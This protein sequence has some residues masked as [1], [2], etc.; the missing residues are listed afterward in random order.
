MPEGGKFSAER[1]HSKKRDM[2][3]RAMTKT[4]AVLILGKLI[5]LQEAIEGKKTLERFEP[6]S[7]EE[8]PNRSGK[9]KRAGDIK[10]NCQ[11]REG[12]VKT[13]GR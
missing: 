1:A 10:V 3:K 6:I 9:E 7:E 12:G 13:D 8:K 4:E 5:K 2:R 11:T